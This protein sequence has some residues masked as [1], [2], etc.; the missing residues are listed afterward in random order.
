ME[1]LFEQIDDSLDIVAFLL[2]AF[3]TISI[4]S[5]TNSASL[6][7]SPLATAFILI[8]LAKS[9]SSLNKQLDES[10]HSTN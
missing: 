9:T 6:V 4:L 8:F 3:K 7:T 10:M 2:A 1:M 5:C